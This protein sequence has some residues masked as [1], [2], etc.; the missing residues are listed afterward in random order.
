MVDSSNGGFNSREK[1]FEAKYLY[2]EELTFKINARRNR[3]FG[4]WAAE[5]M[6][7][8][9]DK[10]ESYIDEVIVADLQKSHTETV[11][12]KVLKD[13]ETAKVDISEHRVQKEYEKCYETAREMLIPKKED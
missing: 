7:Y 4:Q 2:D 8:S 11:F 10:A 5:L 3:L 9:G 1:A 12:S 13:L 6:G